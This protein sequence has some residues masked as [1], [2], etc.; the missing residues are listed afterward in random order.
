MRMRA[1]AGP[2]RPRVL[3]QGPL[4]ANGR[5]KKSKARRESY[6]MASGMCVGWKDDRGFGFMPLLLE[7]VTAPNRITRTAVARRCI[8]PSAI[9][10]RR[11][12]PP[13]RLKR[14]QPRPQKPKKGTE[15]NGACP[16]QGAHPGTQHD[17]RQWSLHTTVVE[18][19]VAFWSG[20]VTLSATNEITLTSVEETKGTFGAGTKEIFACYLASRSAFPDDISGAIVTGGTSTAYTV[21]S[22]R[23]YD[24]LSRLDGNLIAFTPHTT[25]GAIV[26]LNVDGV[27]AKPLR[28]SP[29]VELQSNV[30]LQGT[31]YLALYN[32]SDD[33]FYLHGLGANTY[34]IPLG[35]GMD[36][37]LPTAPSSAFAFPMARRSRAK[38]RRLSKATIRREVSHLYGSRGRGA[39]RPHAQWLVRR[40]GS[41]RL[42]HYPIGK[43]LRVP[44]AAFHRMLEPTKQAS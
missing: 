10:K 8:S 37:W 1:F 21:T 25:N 7:R 35:C 32:H 43:L 6:E 34:G 44:K 15:A 18:P 26:T 23:V 40:G 30:L 41:W 39:F 2:A 36:F 12:K 3:W 11:R 5:G 4:A 13:R 14:K 24:T 20:I 19:G 22:H 33:A 31:P 17:C 29:G 28:P 9:K 42:S 27:G 16:H 38:Q